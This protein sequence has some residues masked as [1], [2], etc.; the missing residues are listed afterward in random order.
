MRTPH[1]V[2]AAVLVSGLAAASAAQAPADQGYL[3]PPK[4]IVD[5]LDQPPPPEVVLSP[6][7]DVVAVLEHAAD[8]D[9]RRAGPADAAAGRT[10]HRSRPPTAGTGRARRGRSR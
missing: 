9:D 2:V 3:L 8:A 5:I 7:R 4:V 1:V 10:A 6:S